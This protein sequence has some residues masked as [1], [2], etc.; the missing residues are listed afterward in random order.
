MTDARET[1]GVAV[2]AKRTP[3]IRFGFDSRSGP[4]ELAARLDLPAGRPRAYA[5]LVH[6]FTCSMDLAITR[7]IAEGLAGE[8]LAVLR[9]DL[10]GH[11][12][13][14]GVF[15]ETNFSDYKAAVL[16]AVQFMRSQY[17]APTVLVGHSLGG[18]ALPRR[19]P[20]FRGH[21][22]C[23]NRYAGGCGGGGASDRSFTWRGPRKG[24]S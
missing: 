14:G 5:L 21:G 4:I 22:G 8:G 20:K 12:K 10:P 9:F 6:G 3:P 11:G 17:E 23:H 2:P 18:A 15:A 16:A 1:I 24:R 13:S 7:R 19:R